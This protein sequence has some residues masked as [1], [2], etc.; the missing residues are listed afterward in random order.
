[1]AA[2]HE[3]TSTVGLGKSSIPLHSFL[4]HCIDGGKKYFLIFQHYQW[5]ILALNLK[6]RAD[7]FPF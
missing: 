6:F 3:E 1:M 2:A 4:C 5:G 7:F